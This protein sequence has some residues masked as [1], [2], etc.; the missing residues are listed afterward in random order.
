MLLFCYFISFS[1]FFHFISLHLFHTLGVSVM[2]QAEILPSEPDLVHTSVG[3]SKMT[4]GT[5]FCTVIAIPKVYLYTKITQEW[6]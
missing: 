1:I 5:Y 4:S 2:L 3:K 6:N